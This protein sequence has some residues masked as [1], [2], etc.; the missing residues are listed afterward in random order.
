M[1]YSKMN[2]KTI[3]IPPTLLSIPAA[4][5]AGCLGMPTAI[6]PWLNADMSLFN[7]PL[8]K[9]CALQGLNLRPLPCE[10]SALPLS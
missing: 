1:R 4:V 5:A 9:W 8:R 3:K 6:W 7:H 2:W 10:G